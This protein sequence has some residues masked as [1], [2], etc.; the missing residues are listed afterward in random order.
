MHIKFGQLLNIRFGRLLNHKKTEYK[1]RNRLLIL[2][3]FVFSQ[4][5][6]AQKIGPFWSFYRKA[7]Q[8]AK[9][10]V[11]QR[12][13]KSIVQI[14]ISETDTLTTHYTIVCNYDKKDPYYCVIDSNYA[15]YTEIT[16]VTPNQYIL[17]SESTNDLAVL[18]KVKGDDL[19]EMQRSSREYNALALN[20]YQAHIP[21]LTP[22]I[23][24]MVDKKTDTVIRNTPCLLYSSSTTKESYNSNREKQ[25]IT[26][27]RKIYIDKNTLEIDSIVKTDLY[28]S[29]YRLICKERVSDLPNFDYNELK[30]QLDFSNPKYAHYSRHDESNLPYRMVYTRNKETTQAILDYPITNLQGQVTKLADMEGWVLLDFWQF[31]CQPCFAQFKKF[32]HERDSIGSSVLEKEGVQ[33]LSIHPYSDNMEKIAQIGEKYHVSDYLYSAKGMN[34]QLE[35]NGYPTYYLISPDKKV[36][37]K[38]NHLGDYSEIIGIVKEYK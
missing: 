5:T 2:V 38:T 24:I 27:T 31:G 20:Y 22:Y 35:M 18:N 23:P 15:D 3:L 16:K 4:T 32:A 29:G 34:G 19:Y 11:N 8:F 13:A 25:I 10:A 12:T 21:K 26:E 36:A 30:Q 7:N 37:L 14:W 28:D 9:N 33:I 1:M 17:V 6:F